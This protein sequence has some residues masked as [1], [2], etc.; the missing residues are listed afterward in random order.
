[1]S[2]SLPSTPPP[3]PPANPPP[4]P[5]PLAPNEARVLGVLVEKALT[6]PAQYPLTLNSLTLG[7]NQKNNRHPVTN[8]S[9]DLVYDA[10]DSLR[11]KGYVREAVLSGSR[12][13]KF[14]HNAREVLGLE[15]P[16]LVLLTELMLRGPESLGE[17]RQ[18]AGRM[19]PFESLEAVKAVLD[20]MAARPQPLVREYPPP[21]GGRA[22]LFR[23]LLA[24]DAHP[25]P[26]GATAG[27]DREEPAA[28]A[29]ARAA[30]SPALEARIAQL[31]ADV[32]RLRAAVTTMAAA[33]GMPD[34]L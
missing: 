18:N 33:L 27:G 9:E 14:K 19:H 12:V 15:T 5:P 24:P 22:H 2:E 17:L 30:S 13:P 1:M 26:T 23:Q 4:A 28:P 3:K 8:L 21:P 6:T 7:C 16:G 11:Q 10:V 32:T 34:P 29:S 31:E 20:E 25:E